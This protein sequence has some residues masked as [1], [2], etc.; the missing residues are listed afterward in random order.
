MNNKVRIAITSFQID[1]SSWCRAAANSPDL[2]RERYRRLVRLSNSIV[3]VR[4]KPE[5][6]VF[7]E[8]AIPRRWAKTIAHHFLNEGIS[9]ITGVEYGP[10]KTDLKCVVNDVR[11][12]LTDN[13]LGYPSFCVL[14][15]R[16][17]FPAHGERDELRAKFGLSLAAYDPVACKKRLYRHFGFHFG[18][19]ICSELTNLD[20]R[21]AMRGRVDN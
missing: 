19:L 14:T 1:E 21:Q 5:Y 16:K 20:H 11:M 10:H 2:S 15:P 13:R 6:V 7:P 17:G 18:V 4:P 12:Y 8:L 9:L 3:K